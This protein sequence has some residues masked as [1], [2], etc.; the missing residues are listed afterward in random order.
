MD[1]DTKTQLDY[2][3]IKFGGS[4]PLLALTKTSF[5]DLY[6]VFDTKYISYRSH[7]LDI[8]VIS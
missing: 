4:V 1:A 7:I 3:T 8:E 2:N 6:W 5:M